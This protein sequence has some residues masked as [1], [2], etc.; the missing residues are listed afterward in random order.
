MKKILKLAVISFFVLAA[1]GSYA[2]S[3]AYD[4]SVRFTEGCY[5]SDLT[6]NPIFPIG[7]VMTG[8][9]VYDNEVS[10]SQ[11][12]LPTITPN[13]GH[14]SNYTAVNN[15]HATVGGYNYGSKVSRVAVANTNANTSDS[16]GKDGFFI[17]G[18]KY[19]SYEDGSDILDGFTIGDWTLDAYV[20]YL[21][22][23]SSFLNDQAL[24]NIIEIP[25][26]VMVSGY[27]GSGVNLLFSNSIGEERLV[28]AFPLLA[29]ARGPVVVPEP[30]TLALLGL[31]LAGLGFARRQTKA[32]QLKPLL[33]G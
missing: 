12:D 33:T 20:L 23:G 2:L 3:M 11:V 17:G 1:S 10:A 8:S 28:R 27:Q 9:F 18:G 19:G 24:L 21:V 22:G 30:G 31:G 6:C 26:R 32:K 13:Y 14:K 16:F 25:P 7:T 15:F 5:T 29:L 4:F